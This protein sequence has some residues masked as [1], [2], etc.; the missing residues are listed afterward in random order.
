MVSVPGTDPYPG[1]DARGRALHPRPPRLLPDGT[2]SLQGAEFSS[3]A[4]DRVRQ[5]GL[6]DSP[7]PSGIA[8]RSLARCLHRDRRGGTAGS[9]GAGSVPEP[10]PDSRKAT[11]CKPARKTRRSARHQQTEA[12]QEPCDVPCRGRPERIERRL[13]IAGE[14]CSQR[15]G[16]VDLDEDRRRRERSGVAGDDN[17]ILQVRSAAVVVD[18]GV[19]AGVDDRA[20]SGAG[21]SAM[22]D[23]GL[24]EERRDG[25]IGGRAYGHDVRGR[26]VSVVE[27]RD[28]CVSA[29]DRV[30]EPQRLEVGQGSD[31]CGRIG[32]NTVRGARLEGTVGQV[33]TMMSRGTCLYAAS[34]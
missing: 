25:Q 12:A 17:L 11:A 19:K 2:R 33:K 13:N 24:A 21:G 9:R 27:P 6:K 34:Q 29:I 15:L 16:T 23:D 20:D 28:D 7:R 14:K 10:A 5:D 26:R 32:T 18:V 30:A 1:V 4:C 8:E 3:C 22:L 31:P